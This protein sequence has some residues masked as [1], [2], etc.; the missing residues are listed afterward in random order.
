MEI[1]LEAHSQAPREMVLDLDATDTPLHGNQEARFFH[2]YYNHY[3]YLPLYIFCGDHL[4]C[5]RLRPSNIDAS[6]GS[7]EEVRRIVGQIRKRWP[8]VRIIWRA[9]SGFCREER[10]AW[11]E[12]HA[13]D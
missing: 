8:K 5:A 12:T 4:L 6:A 2:G 3:C 13:V 7:L 1:F 9:D 10:M 11:C